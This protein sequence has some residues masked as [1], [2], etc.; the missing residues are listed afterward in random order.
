MKTIFHSFI[1]KNW[2][3]R[4]KLSRTNLKSFHFYYLGT[5]LTFVRTTFR[6]YIDTSYS[7]LH[8]SNT[9]IVIIKN[10]ETKLKTKSI[11]TNDIKL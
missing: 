9:L 1:R 2:W 5:L 10:Y 4:V 3:N 8:Q 7:S 6:V 11:I